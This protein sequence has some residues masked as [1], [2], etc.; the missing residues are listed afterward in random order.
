VLTS[1]VFLSICKSANTIAETLF[2]ADLATTGT[3]LQKHPG[4]IYI[5]ISS[6]LDFRT[7]E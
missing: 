7:Y 3:K 5:Y 4:P 1:Y 6:M 2:H